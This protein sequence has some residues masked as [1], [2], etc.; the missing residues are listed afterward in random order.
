[1]RTL[2]DL[3]AEVGARHFPIMACLPVDYSFRK[4]Y[5]AGNPE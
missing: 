1:M 5:G 4:R 3:F 2:P